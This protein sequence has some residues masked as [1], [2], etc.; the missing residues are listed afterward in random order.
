MDVVGAF[1]VLLGIALFVWKA[2][3]RFDRINECGVER[4][5]S[6]R[7]MILGRAGDAALWLLAS[8]LTVGGFLA[9]AHHY[10]DTWGMLVLGPVYA[11]MLVG[12]VPRRFN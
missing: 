7:R 3:R 2:M 8:T 10:E 6:Y 5:S 12:I 9:I 1:S 4:F 11:W